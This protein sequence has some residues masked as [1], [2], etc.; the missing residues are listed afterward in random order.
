MIRVRSE[1]HSSGTA[2]QCRF[3]AKLRRAWHARTA[4]H[5]Q[6]MAE[7]PFMR[8]AVSARQETAQRFTV[9]ASIQRAYARQKLG[10]KPFYESWQP[11]SPSK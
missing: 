4:A 5:H 6:N 1:A 11:G 8:D 7:V 2:A 10:I 3:S 9:Q